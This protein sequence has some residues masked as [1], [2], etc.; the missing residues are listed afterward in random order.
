MENRSDMKRKLIVIGV[1]VIIFVICDVLSCI[2]FHRN[3]W[4]WDMGPRISDFIYPDICLQKVHSI[5]YEEQT[6]GYLILSLGNHA[7]LYVT[8]GK[9]DA[10]HQGVSVY[11]K[12]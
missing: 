2:N 11:I 8:E 12:L 4:K 6:Q 7:F 5:V 1:I 9:N 10:N 3:E